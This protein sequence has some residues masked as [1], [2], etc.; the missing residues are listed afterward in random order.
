MERPGVV[1]RDGVR[2]SGSGSGRAPG[3]AYKA[4][5]NGAAF[6]D[7]PF[8]WAQLP[9]SGGAGLPMGNDTIIHAASMSKPICVTAFVALIEDWQAA[10]D[11]FNGRGTLAQTVTCNAVGTQGPP[12]AFTVTNTADVAV[13]SPAFLTS[14]DDPDDFAGVDNRHVAVTAVFHEP[15][16]LDRRLAGRHR[17]RIARHDLGQFRFARALVLRQD[18]VDGVATGKDAGKAAVILDHQHGADT[19]VS[20]ASA[21]LADCRV[22]RQRQ[23]ILVSHNVRHFPHGHTLLRSPA[24]CERASP[25]FAGKSITSSSILPA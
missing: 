25:G 4:R 14:G 18:A 9:S 24:A 13:Q 12:H 7:A 2:C 21:G 23:R 22:R 17:V 19:P 15:Q 10:W 16:P 3:W 5:L 11:G 1:A 6:C 20:H 8:G